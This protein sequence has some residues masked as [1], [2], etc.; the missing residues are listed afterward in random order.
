MGVPV[1]RDSPFETQRQAYRGLARLLH[2][3]KLSRHFTR[4]KE[5]F[6]TLLIAFET[7][8]SPEASAESIGSNATVGSRTTTTSSAMA[9]TLPPSLN[10]TRPRPQPNPGR[11][12]QRGLPPHKSALP[13]VR[14][15]VGRAAIGSSALR[16][17]AHDAGPEAVHLLRLP[18][19]V[20]MHDRQTRALPSPALARDPTLIPPH[21]LP[22]P[23][24]TPSHEL[25]AA[26][27]AGL[28]VLR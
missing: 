6:Q 13:E 28:S 26:P 7:L 20:W 21:T 15:P 10:R 16:A 25:L 4:A 18:P 5:A 17:H 2:P 8:T 9:S 22:S 23:S 24:P 3:D 12:I 27:R 1:T 11:T 19:H 14:Q